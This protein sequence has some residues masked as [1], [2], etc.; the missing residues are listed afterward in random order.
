MP[1]E[2]SKGFAR[3]PPP[4]SFLGFGTA[5]PGLFAPGSAD[6]RGGLALWLGHCGLGLPPRP[7][8]LGRSPRAR[9]PP[10]WLGPCPP[11]RPAWPGPL[12]WSLP[13]LLI[14][15][16]PCGRQVP[17]TGLTRRY[18][19]RSSPGR[20]APGTRK[21]GKNHPSHRLSAVSS[22]TAHVGRCGCFVALLRRFAPAARLLGGAGGSDAGWPGQRRA[23]RGAQQR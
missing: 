11:A 10:F 12:A 18:G 6:P 9:L 21:G 15:L 16:D 19:C 7:R 3:P 17:H 5:F 20:D 23:G 1:R 4:V 22:P 2:W 14:G 13:V 8:V